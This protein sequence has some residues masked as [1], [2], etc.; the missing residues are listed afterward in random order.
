MTLGTGAYAMLGVLP[1]AL[2]PLIV[3]A[4]LQYVIDS[5]AGV[6]R[7][8]RASFLGRWNGIAYY[9]AVAVPLIRDALGLPAPGPGLV[10]GLGWILVAS[11]LASMADRALAARR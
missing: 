9:V 2:P 11:T 7:P 1:L 4:F 8:L 6:H 5:R 10:M 3:A